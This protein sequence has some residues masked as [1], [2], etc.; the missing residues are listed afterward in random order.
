MN[1][2]KYIWI[3]CFIF[4]ELFLYISGKKVLFYIAKKEYTKKLEQLPEIKENLYISILIGNT[5]F[6]A[7]I[8]KRSDPYSK[9]SFDRYFYALYFNLGYK[10]F[11]IFTVFPFEE[12]KNDTL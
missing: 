3:L 2:K 10:G 11:N 12:F 7:T 9:S 4:M 5:L 6:S 8:N 1:L